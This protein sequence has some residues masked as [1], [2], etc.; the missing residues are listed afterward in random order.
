MALVL[1]VPLVGPVAYFL[2]G[3]SAISRAVRVFLVVGGLAIY[4]GIA[5][6]ALLLEAL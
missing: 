6:L 4:V 2:G 1:I 5:V 3:G